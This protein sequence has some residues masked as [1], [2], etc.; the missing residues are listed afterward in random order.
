[1]LT[2]KLQGDLENML[3]PEF[4]RHRPHRWNWVFYTT[5]CVYKLIQWNYK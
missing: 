2:Y 4:E 5:Y 1:M 3:V